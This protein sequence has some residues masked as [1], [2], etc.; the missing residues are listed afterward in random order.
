MNEK[1]VKFPITFSERRKN[2]MGPLCAEYQVSGRYLQFHPTSSSMQEGEFITIDVMPMQI[3][4]DKSPRKICELIIT[5]EYLM[6]A[7]KHVKTKK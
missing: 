4:E 5:R 3:D 1:I 6:N 7:L 2:K